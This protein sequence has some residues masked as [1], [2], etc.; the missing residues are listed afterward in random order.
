M[1]KT[2]RQAAELETTR[3]RTFKMLNAAAT[4]LGHGDDLPPAALVAVERSL[5]DYRRGL[6]R[7]LA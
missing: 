7:A 6:A 1:T 4:L 3:S 5:A 2:K